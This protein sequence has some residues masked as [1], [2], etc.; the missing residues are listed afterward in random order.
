M[1]KPLLLVLRAFIIFCTVATTAIAQSYSFSTIAGKAGITGTNDGLGQSARFNFAVGVTADPYGNIFVA[2]FLNHAI[3]KMTPSETNWLIT[4]LA[5]LPGTP[6]YTDGTNSDARFDHPAGIAVDAEG[7]L[8]VSERVNHTI[9]K[10]SPV[11]TN[12]VV[13]TVAG[14]AQAI[15]SNDG[16]NTEARFHL[17]SGIT[18]DASNQLYVADT[19]NSTI[20]KIVQQ[21]TNWVITTIAGSP[22]PAIGDFVDGA[23]QDALFDYPYGIS[24]G[25]SGKLYVADFGNNAIREMV[26]IGTN[27]Q[28]TTIA[29]LSGAQ[30]GNDGPG[31]IATFYNPAD[32]TIDKTGNLYVTDQSNSTIRKIVPSQTEWTVSTIAGQVL[33]T[34]SA[35]GVGTNALFK[36]P[37]GITVDRSGNL[38]IAD[39][40][41]STIRQGIPQMTG[42]PSLQL[43]LQGNLIILSW[44]LSASGYALETADRLEPAMSWT[45]VTN[46]V[47]T[48]G[49]QLVVTNALVGQAAFYRLHSS[50]GATP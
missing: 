26:Q 29:G 47:S 13:S 22:P 2:D 10:I 30:G 35:D 25:G 42:A 28:V 5:G 9:R 49:T 15:G 11:G 18:V 21:G 46:G 7:N 1:A 43:S 8:F 44:P 38:F 39:Y 4:T 50:S 45:A 37:W 31:N 19:A 27:W 36:K 33:K 40:S 16:T 48:N 12:W 23:N 3:R 6:G 32:V 17:P 24:V 41:N 20:R 14:L 34:G